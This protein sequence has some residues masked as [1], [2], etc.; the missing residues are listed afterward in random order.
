MNLMQYLQAHQH[1]YLALYVYVEFLIYWSDSLIFYNLYKDYGKIYFLER[2]KNILISN[3]HYNNVVIL[4]LKRF[5]K[6]VKIIIVERTPI[7]ELEIFFGSIDLIK[8]KIIVSLK[9][10][11]IIS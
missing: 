5:F 7:E 11:G 8:K 3:I 4:F 10:L 6:P 1:A 2:K 9:I